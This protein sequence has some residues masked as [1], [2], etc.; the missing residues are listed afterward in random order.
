MMVAGFATAAMMNTMTAA[1]IGMSA[2]V[3]AATLQFL[4]GRDDPGAGSSGASLRDRARCA[5]RRPF[6]ATAT[7]GGR[8]F[9][10]RR[11]P[12]PVARP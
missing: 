12:V 3:A 6:L 1:A 7:L 5:R 8:W 9:R 10:R 4:D 11:S 2:K